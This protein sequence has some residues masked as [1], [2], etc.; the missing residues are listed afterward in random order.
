MDDENQRTPWSQV[1]GFKLFII[2]IAAFLAVCYVGC[3][4]ERNLSTDTTTWGPISEQ[5]VV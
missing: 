2:G 5:G 1:P 3:Y 4:L